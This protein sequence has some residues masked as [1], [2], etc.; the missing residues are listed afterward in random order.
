MNNVNYYLNCVIASKCTDKDN[1]ERV[2]EKDYNDEC[3][4]TFGNK[5]VD[6]DTQSVADTFIIFGGNT[7]FNG[8][9]NYNAVEDFVVSTLEVL[10]CLPIPIRLN[11]ILMIMLVLK[12]N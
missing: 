5:S 4:T 12:V 8:L 11:T 1:T 9:P 7:L 6:D 2:F 3:V 10:E